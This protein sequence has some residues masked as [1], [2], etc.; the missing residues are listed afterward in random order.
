MPI[1]IE[2]RCAMIYTLMNKN[3]PVID[4]ETQ[5]GTILRITDTWNEEYLPIGTRT[6]TGIDVK[7]LNHWWH[8][9]SIPASRT[10]IKEALENMG[11]DSSK[12]LLE[13]SYGLSLSD[14]YWIRPDHSKIQWKDIN[15]FENPFSEDVGSALF[16]GQFGGDF[17]SPDNTSDGW[18]RK[19]WVIQNQKRVLLKSGSG[20]SQQEPLNEVLANMICDRLN[21]KNSEKYLNSLLGRILFVVQV[22][23]NNQEFR[24]YKDIVIKVKS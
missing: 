4:F 21:I 10:G 14:Q 17:M 24:N 13:K 18:L 3:N 22:D 15:F 8:G 9:R 6:K 23:P 5:M 20:E 16:G 2:R 19:K 1:V 12:E 11:I 7:T